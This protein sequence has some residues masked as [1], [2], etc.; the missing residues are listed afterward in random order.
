MAL[1]SQL[2]PGDRIATEYGPATVQHVYLDGA[3]GEL[4][5]WFVIVLPDGYAATRTISLAIGEHAKPTV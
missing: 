2:R 3:P 1:A 4:G 5:R